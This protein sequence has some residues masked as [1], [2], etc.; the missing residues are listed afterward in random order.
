VVVAVVRASGRGALDFACLVADPP[1]VTVCILLV[2][3]VVE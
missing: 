3:M 1:E 2:V